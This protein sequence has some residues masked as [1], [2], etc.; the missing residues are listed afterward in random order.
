MAGSL[1]FAAASWAGEAPW[2]ATATWQGGGVSGSWQLA[3]KSSTKGATYWGGPTRCV[4][5]R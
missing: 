4:S 5:S 2:G 3:P 1:A